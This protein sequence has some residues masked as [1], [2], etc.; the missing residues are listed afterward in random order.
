[1]RS[2]ACCVDSQDPWQPI[3]VLTKQTEQ[4]AQAIFY[5]VYGRSIL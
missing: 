3:E 1:M 5:I 4:P 2:L